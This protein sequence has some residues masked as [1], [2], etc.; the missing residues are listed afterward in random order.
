V[1]V[2]GGLLGPNVYA[3]DSRAEGPVGMSWARLLQGLL[4]TAFR[5]VLPFLWNPYGGGI[6]RLSLLGVSLQEL[7]WALK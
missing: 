3:C 2:K 7:G 5:V 4:P 1:D 6:T